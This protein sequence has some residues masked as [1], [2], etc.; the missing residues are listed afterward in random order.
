MILRQVFKTG[1]LIR[2]PADHPQ[3]WA[4]IGFDFPASGVNGIV[5]AFNGSS[6]GVSDNR[7]KAMK[8]RSDDS[9]RFA[10]LTGMASYSG[11]STTGAAVGDELYVVQPTFSYDEPPGILRAKF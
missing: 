5:C 10:R 2:V 8:Y 3:G 6:A 7:S 1:Q 4:L 9:W 11:Q